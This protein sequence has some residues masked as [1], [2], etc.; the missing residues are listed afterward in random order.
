MA[1]ITKHPKADIALLY[2][3][4]NKP[5]LIGSRNA[6]AIYVANEAFRKNKP[7][8]SVDITISGYQLFNSSDLL[9]KSSPSLIVSTL[10]PYKDSL[11][12]EANASLVADYGSPVVAGE[13]LLGIV[14]EIKQ[15]PVTKDMEVLAQNV[16][17]YRRWI[18]QIAY[19]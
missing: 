12:L 16:G 18:R 13:Y 5:L 4:A 14:K 17:S 1:S 3:P 7:Q 2:M 10:G 6:K 19:L 8:M 15:Q 9:Y 11:V